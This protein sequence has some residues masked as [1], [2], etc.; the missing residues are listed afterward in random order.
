MKFKLLQNISDAEEYRYNDE[1]LIISV[2]GWNNPT[3]WF[4]KY[5][6]PELEEYFIEEYLKFILIEIEEVGYSTS[7]YFEGEDAKESGYGCWLNFEKYR[8]GLG[9]ATIYTIKIIKKGGNDGKNDI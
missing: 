9:K 1:P 8:K 3:D 7:R 6:I 5:I 2:K 4:E